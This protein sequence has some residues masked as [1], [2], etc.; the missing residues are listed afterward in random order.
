MNRETQAEDGE[1]GRGQT[2]HRGPYYS[3]KFGF[4]SLYDDVTEGFKKGD[5]T[6]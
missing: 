1:A 2:A 3:P 5:E 6:A 4:Y